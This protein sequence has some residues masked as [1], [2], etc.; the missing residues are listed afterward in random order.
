[1]SDDTTRRELKRS[2]RK[3]WRLRADNRARVGNV[4]DVGVSFR[5]SAAILVSSVCYLI[6]T[7]LLD[8]CKTTFRIVILY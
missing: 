5:I 7:K 4:N 8:I 6:V 1:M 3:K 2:T